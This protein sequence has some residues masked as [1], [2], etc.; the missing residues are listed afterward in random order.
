MVDLN[1]L[2]LSPLLN[3][4]GKFWQGTGKSGKHAELGRDFLNSYIPEKW[5]NTGVVSGHYDYGKLLSEG[6]TSLKIDEVADWLSSW[7]RKELEEGEMGKRKTTSLTSIF[8]SIDLGKGR[9]PRKDYA[10]KVLEIETDSIFPGGPPVPPSIRIRYEDLYEK[11]YNIPRAFDFR[12]GLD[13]NN[14]VRRFKVGVRGMVS[15]FTNGKKII[16]FELDKIINS[17]VE[18]VFAFIADAENIPSW[19]ETI[20]ESRRTSEGNIGK[21]T[22]YFMQRN[23]PQGRFEIILEILEYE[24]NKFICFKTTSGPSPYSYQYNFEPIGEG[25]VKER[26]TLLSLTA[27]VEVEG[28]TSVTRS[29]QDVER[30]LTKIKEI[31]EKKL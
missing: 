20:L 19:D 3:D 28:L 23:L 26:G 29:I 16:R 17:P 1:S 5:L 8:S 18:Q 24:L 22:K 6:V 12:R 21:G 7:E 15:S 14:K 11:I 31:L 13:M 10:L 4:I 27:E 9:S 2:L 25:T 30:G